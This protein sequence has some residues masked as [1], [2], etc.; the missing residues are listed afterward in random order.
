M[1]QMQIPAGAY[2]GMTLQIQLS[3][4]RTVAMQVPPGVAPGA[5]IQF[6]IPPAAA[7]AYSPPAQRAFV[8]PPAQSQVMNRDSTYSARNSEIMGLPSQ[9]MA[10]VHSPSHGYR[11]VQHKAH[12]TAFQSTQER[13]QA[14]A[15]F[16]SGQIRMCFWFNDEKLAAMSPTELA[17]NI[18]CCSA[19]GCCGLLPCYSKPLYMVAEDEIGI[20]EGFGKFLHVAHPGPIVLESPCNVDTQ[21]IRRRVD[22]R[23]NQQ[24]VKCETKTKDSVF[25]TVEVTVQFQ[26]NP[27]NRDEAAVSAT[28][29]VENFRQLLEDQIQDIVRQKLSKLELDRAFVMKTDLQGEVETKVGEAINEYGYVIVK[30]LVTNFRP[31]QAVVNEMNNIYT[32][33]LGKVVSGT[34]ADTR[35]MVEVMMAEAEAERKQLRG[36]G[37]SLMR[38][39]YLL[40]IRQ[41]LDDFVEVS[42]VR[43][44]VG[45]GSVRGM[46]VLHCRSLVHP[47]RRG[48]SSSNWCVHVAPWPLLAGDERR[49]LRADVG[50]RAVH[51]AA[52]AALRR[53][54]EH[55]R[56]LR[57]PS[58]EDAERGPG[59][60]AAALGRP[61]HHRPPPGPP[62]GGPRARPRRPQEAPAQAA[63]CRRARRGRRAGGLAQRGKPHDQAAPGAGPEQDQPHGQRQGGDGQSQGGDAPPERH[64]DP[65]PVMREERALSRLHE[66][67]MPMDLYTQ[68]HDARQSGALSEQRKLGYADRSRG[69]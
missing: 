7:P 13:K 67:T 36:L 9:T 55:Q 54:E 29:K 48:P 35:K 63:R 33:K 4:G 26:I 47:T 2:P 68:P 20:V 64:K 51:A 58:P 28:Y 61:G 39:A 21:S 59:P 34:Q 49:R 3:D 62:P 25:C 14:S 42:A 1:M 56:R 46:W 45:E 11:P 52:P 12:Q 15:K 31:A 38:Q 53:A 6:A 50:G 37:V 69:G 57:R 32:Q 40:G 18:W 30:A 5:T 24:T 27:A 44:C 66:A 8:P 23:V 41:C 19:G 10:P 60:A 16:G 22:T 65:E 17:L 43:T